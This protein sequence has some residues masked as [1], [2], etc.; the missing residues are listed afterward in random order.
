MF[1]SMKRLEAA[2]EFWLDC[3]DAV[4]VKPDDAAARRMF[5][6]A[7]KDVDYAKGDLH[8]LELEWGLV[9]ETPTNPRNAALFRR[10][11]AQQRA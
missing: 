2:E 5:D 11:E 10:L 7:Q 9:R 8:G 3:R 4:R 6:D 1:P